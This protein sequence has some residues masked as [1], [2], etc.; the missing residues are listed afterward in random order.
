MKI[1]AIRGRNLA[2]LAGDFEVDFESEPLASAGLFA[3][4]G[5]TGSGKS[6]L[7]DALCLALYNDT[8]RTHRTSG[9]VPD[10]GEDQLTVQDPRNLLRRGT[11][12]GHAEVDFVANDGVAYRSRWS[13][14]RAHGRAGGRLQGVELRLA[15]R[16]DDVPIG[17]GV[18]EVLTEIEARVGLTFEQFTRAVLLAQN[19]FFAFLQAGDNERAELLEAL[20]GTG[21]LAEISKRAFERA[22]EERQELELLE[23]RLE[24]EKSLDTEARA[25][26]ETKRQTAA[27]E[28]E[29]RQAAK[30]ELEEQKRW[31]E[32]HA[33]AVDKENEARTRLEEARARREAAAPRRRKLARIEAV[34]PAR[35]KLEA[36]ERSAYELESATKEA[37]EART[38]VTRAE[39]EAAE[40]EKALTKAREELEAAEE[41]A[42]KARPKLDRA[43]VHDA[44]IEGHEKTWQKAKTE[45]GEAVSAEDKAKR[46]L[47]SHRKDAEAKRRKH[48]EIARWLE[49]RR[50][51]LEGL[52]QRWERWDSLL[53]QAGQRE[54]ERKAAQRQLEEAEAEEKEARQARGDAEPALD[55]AQEALAV[56]E[57]ALVTAESVEALRRGLDEGEPCPVCGA[58]HHP[59]AAEAPELEPAS[60]GEAAQKTETARATRDRLARAST[61]AAE[62]LRQIEAELEK[63]SSRIDRAHEKRGGAKA[64]RDALLDELDAAFAESAWREAW[65]EDPAAFHASSRKQ[66]ETWNS[67]SG[68]A[69]E[70]ER[71]LEKLE[72]EGKALETALEGASERKVKAEKAFA[73]AGG[74]R[75]ELRKK[76]EALFGGRPVEEVEKELREAVR[77]A[78]TEEGRRAKASAEAAEAKARAEERVVRSAKAL[79]EKTEAGKVASQ[80]LEAWIESHDEV[81]DLEELRELLGP[82]SE[83]IAEERRAL[84][85]LETAIEKAV[86]VVQEREERRSE[87]EERRPTER[88]AEE[89]VEALAKTAGE[90]E[91]SRKVV[92]ELDVELRRD[93]ER[94][95]RSE[96]L[97]SELER[98][99][100]VVDRWDKLNAL[101]GSADGKK[102]RNY[103][104]QLTLDV[105]LGYANEHLRDLARRYRLERIDDS[106]GLLVIDRDMGDEQRSVHSLSGGETFLVSLALA[107]G[108][109]SLSSHR[110][111]VESLFIDEG[112]GSLDAD[113]LGLAMDA[114]DRLQALG[115]KVG[116]ISHVQEMTER[117]ATRVVVRK[118]AGGKSEVRVSDHAELPFVS[119]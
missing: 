18:R 7:L 56:A 85:A 30:S 14:R 48:E 91:E 50:E 117:I 62:T 60:T 39:T 66:A 95:Q 109:A 27:S 2:S 75:G 69:G 81:E 10:V 5:P 6:T 86:S 54:A 119:G 114:L 72:T 29:K 51:K 112:F 59:Y 12:E 79:E 22:K 83:W 13:V 118:R 36:R 23:A 90:L 93:D 68:E 26:L 61:Q 63:I 42:E 73:E 38:L 15:R 44:E 111:K 108:L 101:I 84:Q 65:A 47:E 116:V 20:T 21:E 8:P 70:L 113:T 80:E 28:L 104:Q 25:E 34:A 89:V 107:L 37:A 110:V 115:R 52:G 35:P 99:G 77:A 53:A 103:G 58:T 4:S 57:R 106:L 88:G 43:R 46:A 102:F 31:H 33:E 100:E 3:I 97:R 49:D 87:L 98:Q 82:S 41:A 76:R 40:A 55:R 78:K 92:N 94:R 24:G 96:E 67:Q 16:D 71:S 17:E 9:K 32:A 74:R 105:L 45:R 19:Q 1:L 11:G 64:Q